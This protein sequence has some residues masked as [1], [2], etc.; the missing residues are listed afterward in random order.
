MSLHVD[1]IPPG[2]CSASCQSELVQAS[3]LGFHLLSIKVVL[4]CFAVKI[5]KQ[6]EGKI[7]G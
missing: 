7:P 1:P 3:V 6:L 5:K 4:H 2:E